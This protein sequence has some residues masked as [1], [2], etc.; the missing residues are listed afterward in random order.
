MLKN[1]DELLQRG[2]KLEDLMQKTSDLS[3]TSVE[4]YRSARSQNQCCN[5]Y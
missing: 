5:L 1:M 2:E 3:K 4:F